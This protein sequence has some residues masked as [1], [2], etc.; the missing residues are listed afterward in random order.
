M[1]GQR[2]VK[3]PTSTATEQ[4][5][6]FDGQAAA[7][8]L[9]A[10][11][12]EAEE[13]AE[14]LIGLTS[15]VD[16]EARS[17][18]EE[19]STRSAAIESELQAVKAERTHAMETVNSVCVRREGLLEQLRLVGEELS[20]AEATCGSLAV[21]EQKLYSSHA[22]LAEELMRK[23]HEAREHSDV[24]SQ[25]QRALMLTAGASRIVEEQLKAR[26]A[27]VSVAVESSQRFNTQEQAV[28]AAC[29]S[30]SRAQERELSELMS[31]WDTFI[32]GPAAV[33]LTTHSDQAEAIH[34]AN[35]RALAVV[36]RTLQTVEQMLV[37]DKS[38]NPA[39][40]ILEGIPRLSTA[41][42]S[43]PRLSTPRLSSGNLLETIF[44][45]GESD[46]DSDDGVAE[47]LSHVAPKYK[48]MRQQLANNLER[49]DELTSWG[50]SLCKVHAAIAA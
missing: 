44:G 11:R 27:A 42:L 49:L 15:E 34:L 20:A 9:Q 43:T 14:A 50:R 29:I 48:K 3:G 30:S 35:V 24:A 12:T 21:R 22:E 19:I 16:G 36:D 26:G 45:H 37:S 47:R 2:R 7:S 39:A 46:G 5:P 23:F 4:L 1:G 6:A 33:A 38:K 17:Y 13:R 32:W 25:R 8:T 10:F 31:I 40:S 18:Q 41:R 28:R